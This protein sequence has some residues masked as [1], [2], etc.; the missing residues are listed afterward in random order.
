M[1]ISHIL[2]HWATIYKP[3]SHKPEGDRLYSKSFFRIR[4]ID[5]ENIFSRNAN[6]IHSP[7]MLQSVIS[8][9]KVE[10]AKQARATCQVWFLTKMKDTPQT[11]GRFDGEKLEKTTETLNVM[12]E[13]LI[14]W[15]IEVRRTGVCPITNRSF[16]DNPQTLGSIQSIDIK[17]FSYGVI[18]DIYLGQWLVA[19]LDWE[20]TKPLYNFECGSTG[21]YIENPNLK[22]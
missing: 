16:K 5:M 18:P 22:I 20:C 7:C 14:A 17:S 11:L 6:L 4:F 1:N 2:E 3:L 12:C 10:N 13:D 21:K 9:G 15:L 19:G 8:T